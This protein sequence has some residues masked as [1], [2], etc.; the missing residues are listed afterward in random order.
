MEY[1]FENIESL[2]RGA[3]DPSTKSS[4]AFDER[5]AQIRNAVAVE[6]DRI[7]KSFVLCVWQLENSQQRSHYVQYHQHRLIILIDELYEI[8]RSEKGKS[9]GNHSRLSREAFFL[10]DQLED[11]LNT[12][13][14]NLSEYFSLDIKVPE[15][16][17]QRMLKSTQDKCA[18]IRNYDS[19]DENA[20]IAICL[21]DVSELQGREGITYRKIQYMETLTD[22]IND[23][24]KKNP[25][26]RLDEE[27]IQT[28]LFSLNYNSQEYFKYY[29]HNVQN[30]LAELGSDSERLEKLAFHYKTINQIPP[31][32]GMVHDST[33]KG[34]KTQLSEWISEEVQ[35][36]ERKRDLTTT[37]QVAEN[38]F[39][40]KDFKLEFDMSVSQFAFFIKAFIET[41]VIQNKNV[42]E[43]IRFL[44]KFVKT[45]RSENI[46][47]ESF[48]IKYY[49]VESNTKDAVKN[50]LHTAIGFIN[51]N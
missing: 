3:I 46:S 45:K 36:L 49:N 17:K 24:F 27:E 1:E 48:R 4:K 26:N 39:A 11:I 20:L 33:S 18:E 12:I 42:S 47:Y 21:K 7:K 31:T 50:A 6:C 30:E 34:I 28:L 51:N 23:L 19:S 32:P 5:F 38:D 40:K 44:A 37:S 35:F 41:G 8:S 13:R 15:P 2:I 16:D 43:L 25:D 14:K 10:Y 29:V 9:A 22:S